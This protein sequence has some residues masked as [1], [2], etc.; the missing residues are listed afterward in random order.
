MHKVAKYSKRG[1][2][3]LEMVMVIAIIVILAAVLAINSG[4]IYRRAAN[5]SASVTDSVQDVQTGISASENKLANSYH[6]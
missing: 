2:T 1:F 5:K 4:E 3:L 6:F